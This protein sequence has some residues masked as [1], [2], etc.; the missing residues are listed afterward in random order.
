M[1]DHDCGIAA[2]FCQYELVTGMR[3]S[4]CGLLRKQHHYCAVGVAWEVGHPANGPAGTGHCSCWTQ[5]T[6]GHS[7]DTPPSR[8]SWSHFILVVFL[9]SEAE[10]Q[11]TQN[12]IVLFP[13]GDNEEEDLVHYYPS[14]TV[15]LLSSL[16]IVPCK[17]EALAASPQKTILHGQNNSSQS[18]QSH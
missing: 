16:T 1:L 14:R 4:P 3:C 9:T 11:S 12:K 5:A 8:W 10:S 7:T 13:S 18:A 2:V 15:P 17:E 6:A